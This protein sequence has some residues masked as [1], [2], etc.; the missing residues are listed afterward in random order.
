METK[1]REHQKSFRALSLVLCHLCGFCLPILNGSTYIV[2]PMD[3]S[4]KTF[5]SL[6]N[7][8]R[9]SPDDIVEF[10][11]S[12]PGGN[13]VF[14]ETLT[15]NG[16]GVPGHPIVIR[17]RKGDKITI[18][19][20]LVRANTVY[21]HGHHDIIFQGL[22]C[23]N[24]TGGVLSGSI[25]LNSCD[26]ITIERCSVYISL[27][28]DG[29]AARRG[30]ATA[31]QCN[32]LAILD[33]SVTTDDA[34]GYRRDRLYFAAGAGIRIVG[35]LVAMHN[36]YSKHPSGHNDGIQTLDCADLLIER[37]LCDREVATPFTQGQGIYCEWYNHADDALSDYGRAV[38]RNNVVFGNGGSFLLQTMVRPGINQ[39]KDPVVTF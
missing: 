39:A 1:R 35:N 22:I 8:H 16:D 15:P 24:A 18:D 13:A 32:R 20:G 12:A 10:Q 9:L 5:A 19:G 31:H 23:R 21:I 29:V 11:A 37:N 17:A 36:A 4:Y 27:A 3:P 6:V 28:G 30:I 7:A 33:S 14:N 34:S 2:G 26:D 38:I 25:T